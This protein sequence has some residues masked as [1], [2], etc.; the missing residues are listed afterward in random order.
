MLVGVS[1]GWP[2]QYGK[3]LPHLAIVDTQKFVCPCSHVNQV[4]F[5]LGTFLVHESVDRIVP[6]HG[7]QQTVHNEEK[8]LTQFWRAAL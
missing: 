2:L 1:L 6:G 4:G 3:I 7:F 8:G 5:A